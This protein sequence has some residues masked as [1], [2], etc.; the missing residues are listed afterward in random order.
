MRWTRGC[1]SRHFWGAESFLR[2]QLQFRGEGLKDGERS[3]LVVYTRSSGEGLWAEL[4]KTEVCSLDTTWPVWGTIMEL[5]FRV[6]IMR[7][8]RCE[9]YK[10]TRRVLR[11]HHSRP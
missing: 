3:F 9:A 6:E 10:V 4:G 1:C 7:Q 2:L 5:Q 8:M 11:D